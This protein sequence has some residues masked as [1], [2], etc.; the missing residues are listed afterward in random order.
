MKFEIR[1]VQDGAVLRVDPDYPGAEPEEVV[2][3][4]TETEELEAFADFLRHLVDHSWLYLS[5]VA[6]SALEM[7]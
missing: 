6:H 5:F 1:R 2:Y 3:Q 7:P 4:E